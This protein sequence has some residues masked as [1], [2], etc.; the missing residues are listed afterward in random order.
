MSNKLRVWHWYD[1]SNMAMPRTK[2]YDV[3]NPFEAAKLIEKLANQDLRNKRID[4]NAFGLEEWDDGLSYPSET[5]GE[6]TEW[7]S[8][9]GE[10]ID[11]FADSL[12]IKEAF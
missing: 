5:E 6:W 7:Y 9:F 12:N 4:T 10:S 1:G 8:R 3:S 2:H 11:D